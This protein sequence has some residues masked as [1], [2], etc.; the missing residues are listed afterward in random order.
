MICMQALDY[1]ENTKYGLNNAFFVKTFKKLD[2]PQSET[3]FRAEF[4]V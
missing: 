1:E 3:N 4:H 2:S